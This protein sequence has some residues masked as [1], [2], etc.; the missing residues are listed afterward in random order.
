[1]QY[2]TQ[3]IM[4]ALYSSGYLQSKLMFDISHT[5]MLN[6]YFICTVQFQMV[7]PYILKIHKHLKMTE[8]HFYCVHSKMTGSKIIAGSQ[9]KV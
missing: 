4:H 6:V 9:S 5:S 3:L 8:T 2:K 1:M 7:Q